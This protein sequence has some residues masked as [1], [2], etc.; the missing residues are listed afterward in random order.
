MYIVKSKV[1]NKTGSSRGCISLN[2]SSVE[3]K[4]SQRIK[5]NL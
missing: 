3:E 2:K 5:S 4:V 1:S